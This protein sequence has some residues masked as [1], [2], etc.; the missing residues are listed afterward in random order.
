MSSGVT[1]FKDV[2]SGDTLFDSTH[3]KSVVDC[4]AYEVRSAWAP[5]YSDA[6]VRTAIELVEAHKLRPLPLTS[7]GFCEYL[8]GYIPKLTAHL[9]NTRRADR[10]ELFQAN[11][12]QFARRV[13]SDFEQF[14]F[15]TGVSG[16]TDDGIAMCFFKADQTTPHFYFMRD[17]VVSSAR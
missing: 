6:G 3:P 15:F 13:L 4:V 8:K 10:L 17:G 5:V 12:Q 14:S 2:F 11:V 16:D 1:L 7:E 9:R